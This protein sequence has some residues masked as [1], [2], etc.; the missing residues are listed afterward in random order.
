MSQPA[1][2][3]GYAFAVLLFAGAAS[4]A[5]VSGKVE[6]LEKGNVKRAVVRN[7]LVYLEG[8]K[9][10]IPASI[11]ERPVS[12]ASREK[13]FEPHVQVVPVKGS[14][15][16]PNHDDIMHNVFS[17]TKGNRFDLGLYKSGAK[18]DF[19]FANAGLV[20]IYCNI[21]PQMSAFLLVRD[22][23]YYVWTT[24][25]GGFR[26]DGVPPGNYT[27]RAWHEEGDAAQPVSITESGASG[28]LVQIDASGYAKRPHMNKF[29]KPYKREKY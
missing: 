28:L 11:R 5:P 25:D 14:V 22:N 7:V 1:P 6:I 3:S 17:L 9:T 26:I 15:S 20:R 18:K 10:E 29:G 16:F 4:A 8:I 27:L 23:P 21:H 19:A 13:T 12:I 2:L 24:P